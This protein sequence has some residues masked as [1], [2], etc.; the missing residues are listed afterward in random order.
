MKRRIGMK[1]MGLR[2]VA[3]VGLALSFALACR[4]AEAQSWAE[5]IKLKGDMRLR[6][7]LDDRE[8]RNDRHRGRVR[9]RLGLAADVTEGLDVA[10]GLATG[11]TDPR[12]TNETLDNSFETP[13][14][15]LDYAYV[16]YAPP[17]AAWLTVY[18]GKFKRKPVLWAPT[19]LLWDSDI[20]PEGIGLAVNR[21]LRPNL[22]LFAGVAMLMVD[23]SRGGGDPGLWV[24]QPGV[25]WDITGDGRWTLKGAV[26]Y[27]AA[28]SVENHALDHSAGTNTLDGNGNLFYD[29]DALSPAVELAWKTGSD[30]VPYAA[31]FAEQITA[32]D[33][34]DTGGAAGFKFGDKKVKKQKTWQIKYIYRHLARNA[35]LDTFPD[36]DAHGGET[37]A[38]GHELVIKYALLDNVVLAIDYYAMD[39]IHDP[40][41]EQ[42][43]LQIDLVMSF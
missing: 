35:W 27:Y 43:I 7:Q 5:K 40:S 41:D 12:S 26:T 38:A 25:K 21:E 36:S 19:D 1:G 29:Y 3:G 42:S 28:S 30:S 39:T 15:R 6:Y 37:N 33:A 31:L 11:G 24:L 34:D 2:I 4:T 9:F 8:G 20:N 23:E 16:A 14:I 32:F 10:A 18:A 13:D 22:D 17:A